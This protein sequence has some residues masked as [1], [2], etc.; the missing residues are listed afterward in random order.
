MALHAHELREG[1][2]LVS[3]DP[4]RLDIRRIHA[5]LT[6]SYW[7]PGVSLDRVARAIGHSLPFGLYAG[8]EQVG[9][10]RVVTD[11]ATLAY[12]ADVYVEGAHRGCGLGKL[13]MRAVMAHPALQDIR[14]WS[15]GTRD[16][17]GLYRQFGFGPVRSPERWME[18]SPPDF[19][20]QEATQ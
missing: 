9:F 1:D 6:T 5:F 17:H 7:S 3:T 16:A 18:I 14:R 13:L 4:S 15:L 2:Y 20:K 11:T 12:I 19:Y 10:A 8:D